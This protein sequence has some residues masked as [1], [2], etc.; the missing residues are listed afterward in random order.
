MWFFHDAISSQ[1][2]NTKAHPSF[3]NVMHS[4]MPHSI[5]IFL[6]YVFLIGS[7]ES[8]EQHACRWQWERERE[9][10]R[11]C[12]CS[13][14][15]LQDNWKAKGIHYLLYKTSLWGSSQSLLVPILFFHLFSLSIVINL[16]SE[17][18]FLGC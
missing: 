11:D 3:Y 13:I 6:Y 1:Y 2:V 10:E 8:T 9:R 16:S 15:Y 7:K 14:R 12:L 4:Q 5:Y 18:L 17:Y